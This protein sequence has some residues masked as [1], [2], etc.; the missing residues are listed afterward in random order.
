MLHK[1][2]PSL[3]TSVIEF[4]VFDS[5]IIVCQEIIA[6]IYLAKSATSHQ[7]EYL[8]SLILTHSWPTNPAIETIALLFR[9][10]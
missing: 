2:L 4:I 8:K 6:F 9:K 3:L 10:F 5:D 7:L 1:I